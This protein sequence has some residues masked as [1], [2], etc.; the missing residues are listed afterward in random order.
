MDLPAHDPW[1]ASPPSGWPANNPNPT[2][3]NYRFEFN[4]DGTLTYTNLNA[5][6]FLQNHHGQSQA[7]ALAERIDDRRPGDINGALVVRGGNA[8]VSGTVNGRVT[9]AALANNSNLIPYNADVRS[10]GNVIVEDSIIYNT[11]PTDEDGNYRPVAGPCLRSGR[12]DGRHGA[13]R[14]AEFPAEQ[15]GA[16]DDDHRRAHHGHGPGVA[17]SGCTD[18]NPT[19]NTGSTI[20]EAI[21]QDGAFF[22]EDGVQMNLSELWTGIPDTAGSW[23]DGEIYL[24]GG[25]VHF[26]RGRRRTVRRAIPQICVRFA[27]SD[28]SSALLPA[29]AG[30]RHRPLARCR[31]QVDPS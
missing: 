12:S 19:T 5:A 6:L 21:N 22:V 31:E 23:K 16:D 20:S 26:I 3:N 10:D 11:H 17:Q 24:T 9:L 14:G 13:D 18:W 8:F 29:D 27:A 2:V 30:H 7:A 28:P 25:V 1:L 4:A 15:F